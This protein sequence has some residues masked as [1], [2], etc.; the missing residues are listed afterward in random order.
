M[1]VLRNLFGSL[2]SG[3]IR[4]AVAVG[5]IAAIGIF[6]VR[7]VV[8][9]ANH[10]VDS[11]NESF[12]QS[13]GTPVDMNDINGTIKKVDRQVQIQVKQAFHISKKNGNANKLIRCIQ[14]AH[15]DVHRIQRCSVRFSP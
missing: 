10:A 2:T 13:F 12:K 7:P 11:A 8:D 3:I 6:L 5:I 9:S 4:L 15:Q 14:H 1:D